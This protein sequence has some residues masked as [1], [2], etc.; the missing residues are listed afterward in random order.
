VEAAPGKLATEITLSWTD[1]G[2]DRDRR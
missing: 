2:P 1:E